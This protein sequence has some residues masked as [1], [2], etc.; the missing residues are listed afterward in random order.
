MS[1][2]WDDLGGKPETYEQI[3]ARSVVLKPRQESE[4]D[5]AER[6]ARGK[7]W[8]EKH[9]EAFAAEFLTTRQE[10]R[11]SRALAKQLGFTGVGNDA[12]E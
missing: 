4:Q 1:R 8:A 6:L 2:A 7:R 12:D 5:M 11:I 9:D 3:L 10:Q